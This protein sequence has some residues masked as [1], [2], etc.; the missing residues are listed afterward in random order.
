MIRNWF[1]GAINYM[2]ELFY[3]EDEHINSIVNIQKYKPNRSNSSFRHYRSKHENYQTQES[4]A[5]HP[6]PASRPIPSSTTRAPQPTPVLQVKD[7]LPLQ[8]ATRLVVQV[9]L[10]QVQAQRQT[11]TQVKALAAQE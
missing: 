7:R 6:T 1:I 3:C 9:R 11:R 4:Q 8:L 10:V 5:L 2:V